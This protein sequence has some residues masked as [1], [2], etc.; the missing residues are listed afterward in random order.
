[1]CQC[2]QWKSY[3]SNNIDLKNNPYLTWLLGICHE[4]PNCLILWQ[5]YK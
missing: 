4:V 5:G 3:A 1:M 2:H